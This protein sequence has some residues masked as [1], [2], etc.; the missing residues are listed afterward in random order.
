MTLP[1]PDPTWHASARSHAEHFLREGPRPMTD[2]SRALF[3]RGG[4]VTPPVRAREHVSGTMRRFT[5]YRRGDIS[6]THDANQVNPPDEPQFEGVVFT[7][8]SCALRWLTAVHCTSVWASFEDAMTIHGHPEY[9]SEIV[10]HDEGV[11]G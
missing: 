6:A 5:M 1:C 8:G 4:W 10:W 9:D 3:P 7:D 2:E 11:V